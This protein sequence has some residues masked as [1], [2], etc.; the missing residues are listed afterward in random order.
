M[1]PHQVKILVKKIQAVRL[2]AKLTKKPF[3]SALFL[4]VVD[5]AKKENLESM[6]TWI[7]LRHG[8]KQVMQMLILFDFNEMKFKS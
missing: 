7:F 3:L 6:Q 4:M 1:S 2:F 5:V 8:L